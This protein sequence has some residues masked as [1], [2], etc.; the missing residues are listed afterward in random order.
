VPQGANA[1]QIEARRQR[2]NLALTMLRGGET[3]ARVAAQYSDAPDS[4]Q[5]GG[6]GWRDSSRLPPLFLDTLQRM[7]PGDVSDILK[8]P[9]GFHIVK[10]SD[11]RTKATEE[12]GSVE[13]SHVRHILIRTAHGVTDSEARDQLLKLRERI[14]AGADF[15]DIAKHSSDDAS[16]ARGG[17]L[18]WIAPGDTVPDFERVVTSLQPGDLS[19]PFQSPFGWHIVQVLERRAEAPNDEH[20]KN[21]AR[22][23]IRTRKSEEAYQDWMRQERDRAYV[24]NRFDER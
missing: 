11:K 23:S 3:F 16:A 15:A 17:D 2:A 13:Q 5:G 1:A 4:L 7:R 14:V 19:Q 9:N 8:S 18:G 24:D 22:Q 6:L 20:K 12:T 10:L 21:A